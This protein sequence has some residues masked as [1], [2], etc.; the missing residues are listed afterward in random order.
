MS[1]DRLLARLSRDLHVACDFGDY[2][3]LG[4][5][6]FYRLSVFP[7][8]LVSQSVAHAQHTTGAR[9]NSNKPCVH[10]FFFRSRK[11][12][13][14]RDLEEKVVREL[15]VKGSYRPHLLRLSRSSP[16]PSPGLKEGCNGQSGAAGESVLRWVFSQSQN[17]S[18]ERAC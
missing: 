15:T 7:P 11:C 2:Q 4:G 16:T 14:L 12:A 17:S 6:C 5:G 18:G 10:H 1:Y 9:F 8:D 13:L 3:P